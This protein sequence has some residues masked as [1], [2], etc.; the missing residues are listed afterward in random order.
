MTH[1]NEHT[2][3][4]SYPI[5]VEVDVI[6]NALWPCLILH[7]NALPYINIGMYIHNMYDVPLH[8]KSIFT[9]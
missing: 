4:I 6:R 3:N 8:V 9:N 2:Y 5:R 1:N 7:P